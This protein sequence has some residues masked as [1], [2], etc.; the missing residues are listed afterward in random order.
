MVKR[1]ILILAIY[2]DAARIQATRRRQVVR[3]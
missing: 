3:Q 2:I 1:L